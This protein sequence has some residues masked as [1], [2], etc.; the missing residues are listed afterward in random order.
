MMNK[1]GITPIVV[2]QLTTSQLD[3]NCFAAF[4]S[5]NFAHC[6]EL[7]DRCMHSN[8]IIFKKRKASDKIF[9]VIHNS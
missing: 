6:I 9:M 4:K 5:R 1:E 8:Y 3:F 2:T 7:H